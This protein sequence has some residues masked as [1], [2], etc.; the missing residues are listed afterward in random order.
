M[1]D[2]IQEILNAKKLGDRK[3]N[4]QD[5]A[6]LESLSKIHEMG[7]DPYP[8][9]KFDVN[10]SSITI[11]ETFNDDEPDALGEVSLC[12]RIMAIR[13][14]GAVTFAELQDSSGRIQLFIRRDNICPG[15]DKSL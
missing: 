8:A 5:L 13:S 3:L 14:K 2:K 12:G 10:T 4:D 11:K 15:E 1:Q 7:V 6:R 9:E